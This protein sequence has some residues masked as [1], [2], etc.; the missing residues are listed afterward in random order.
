MHRTEHNFKG[1][2]QCVP[3]MKVVPQFQSELFPKEIGIF[4]S[5]IIV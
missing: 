5:S 4:T 3:L 2:S 1:I